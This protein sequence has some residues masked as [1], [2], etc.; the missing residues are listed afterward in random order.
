MLK[1]NSNCYKL[2]MHLLLSIGGSFTLPYLMA[3][4]ASPFQQTLS[5]NCKATVKPVPYQ[6]QGNAQHVCKG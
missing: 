5:N 4:K 1:I 2:L 6:C 3:D